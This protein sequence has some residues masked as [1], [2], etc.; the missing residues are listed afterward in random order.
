[1]GEKTLIERLRE[2]GPAGTETW[3]ECEELCVQAAVALSDRDARIAALEEGLRPFAAVAE[4]DIGTDEADDDFF[5]NSNRTYAKA[6]PILV[7]HLRKARALLTPT[8]TEI[9]DE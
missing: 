2:A 5:R 7:G 8:G 9:K 6:P 3:A 4:V 1:M